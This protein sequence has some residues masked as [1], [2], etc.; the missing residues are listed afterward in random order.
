MIKISFCLLFP[1]LVVVGCQPTQR[2]EAERWLSDN[3]R[4]EEKFQSRLLETRNQRREALTRIV[5]SHI[6]VTLTP[7]EITMLVERPGEPDI[8]DN[9]TRDAARR[10]VISRIAH[11]DPIAEGM[12]ASIQNK[13]SARAAQLMNSNPDVNPIA[14]A[15]VAQLQLEIRAWSDRMYQVREQ[16]GWYQLSPFSNFRIALGAVRDAAVQEVLRLRSVKRVM[17]PAPK[18]MAPTPPAASPRRSGLLQ[19]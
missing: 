1:V 14:D 10:A 17:P 13:M 18:E 19:T 16:F 15:I 4:R 11:T 7:D 6:F 3:R 2:E 5:P 9:S 8:K 12:L